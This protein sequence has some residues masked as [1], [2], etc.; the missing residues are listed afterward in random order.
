MKAKEKI[1]VAGW[2]TSMPLMIRKTPVEELSVVELAR[3][4]LS[5]KQARRMDQILLYGVRLGGVRSFPVEGDKAN[6]GTRR[7]VR[8]VV[9]VTRTRKVYHN[10]VRGLVSC[11]HRA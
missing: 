11:S 3:K 4:G 7:M 6:P 10:H 8:G 9:V 1:A 5:G 2:R